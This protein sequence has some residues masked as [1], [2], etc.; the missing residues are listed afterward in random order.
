MHCLIENRKDYDFLYMFTLVVFGS[1]IIEPSL[2]P[3]SF[4]LFIMCTFKNH[5]FK[6]DVTPYV[7]TSVKKEANPISSQRLVSR[8]FVH[9]Q[10]T[11]P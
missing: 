11:V 2:V 7:S 10:R 9:V 6:P 1:F 3:W 5:Y 4:Y 8:R